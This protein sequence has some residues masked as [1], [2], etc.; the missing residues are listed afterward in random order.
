MNSYI[1]GM[2]FLFFFLLVFIETQ[3]F[4]LGN[5]INYARPTNSFMPSSLYFFFLNLR[6]AIFIINVNVKSAN[7]L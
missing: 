6:K 2:N 5:I 4:N 7:G 3:L 1:Y